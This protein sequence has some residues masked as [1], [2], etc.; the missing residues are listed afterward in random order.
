MPVLSSVHWQV[1]SWK[2]QSPEKNTS[3]TL[4]FFFMSLVNKMLYHSK[5]ANPVNRCPMQTKNSVPETRADPRNANP[6]CIGDRQQPSH[7]WTTDWLQNLGAT[8][9]DDSV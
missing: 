4:S 6:H 8:W 5:A 7:D 2:L 3:L 9:S 1:P